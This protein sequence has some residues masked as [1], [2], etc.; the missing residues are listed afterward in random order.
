MWTI[1][2]FIV[3]IGLLGWGIYLGKKSGVD[4][5]FG[6]RVAGGIIVSVIGIVWLTGTLGFYIDSITLN[7]LERVGPGNFD[8]EVRRVAIAEK[9]AN[10]RICTYMAPWLRMP[11]PR[12]E[13]Q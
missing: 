2:L 6:Y 9:R 10:M 1:I 13:N 3:G 7:E 11:E 8:A 4:H 12:K 5:G